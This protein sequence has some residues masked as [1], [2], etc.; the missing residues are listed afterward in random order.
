MVRT[1]LTAL[2][3][4]VLCLVHVAP[5]LALAGSRAHAHG[6]RAELPGSAPSALRR[7]SDA[8]LVAQAAQAED[9]QWRRPGRGRSGEVGVVSSEGITITELAAILC[10]M[11]LQGVQLASAI[12]CTP[13][14][15]TLIALFGLHMVA[16]YER[17]MQEL[18]KKGTKAVSFLRSKGKGGD[19]SAQKASTDV[20]AKNEIKDAPKKKLFC[21]CLG[22]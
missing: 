14:G 22:F 12:I 19:T 1:R 16:T 10:Y 4:A 15:L 9:K 7:S 8:I 18:K 17:P 5:A 20:P 2:A 11:P 21:A 13:Q 3:A 6:L